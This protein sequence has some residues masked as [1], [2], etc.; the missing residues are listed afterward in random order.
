MSKTSIAVMLLLLITP[1][2]GQPKPRELL[3]EVEPQKAQRLTEYNSPSL[4]EELYFSLRHRIVEVQTGLLLGDDDLT[5]TPFDDVTPML[6][7]RPKS[8]GGED[9]VHGLGRLE[10][11]LQPQLV[12]DGI[13]ITSMISLHAWDVDESGSASDSSQNRFKF[14]PRWAINESDL[15]VLEPVV[16]GEGATAGPPP[17]TPEDIEQHKRLKKLKKH[18]FYSVRGTFSSTDGKTFGLVPLRYTPKYSVIFELDRSKVV[19]THDPLPGEAERQNVDPVR[20]AQY[21]AFRRA[22][23]KETNKPIK[24]DIP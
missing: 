17:Q 19:V 16:D 5:I 22:L 1:A 20:A 21:E 3:T 18:V 7:K 9:D 11:E 8:Q 6:F 23:P 10:T 15:P 24:G 12:P 13:E 4:Q 14:S 2:F